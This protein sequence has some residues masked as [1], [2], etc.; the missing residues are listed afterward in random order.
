MIESFRI[1]NFR[2]FAD[3]AIGPLGRVNLIAGKNNGNSQ[4]FS[5]NCESGQDSAT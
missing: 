5:R 2:C 4:P 1:Q 3:L